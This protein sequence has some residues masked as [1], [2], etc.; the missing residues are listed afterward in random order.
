LIFGHQKRD[1]IMEL[2]EAIFGRRSVRDYLPD[3]VPQE[4]INRLVDAAI[5]APNAINQQPWSFAVV[6]ERSLLDQ[7]SRDAKAHLLSIRATAPMPAHLYERLADPN[8]HIFY[9]APTLIVI[10]AIAQGPWI[11]EDCALA[12]ENLMLAAHGAGFGSCWIGLA[13]AWFGT[14]KGKKTIGVPEPHVP[15]APII[16]GRPRTPAPAVPRKA[17][18]VRWIS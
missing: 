17:P 10:S 12:A 6:Q 14:P 8:F 13:Q 5:H 9:H 15:V 2:M 3:A 18:E 4:A 11:V 16:V 1:S 7:I